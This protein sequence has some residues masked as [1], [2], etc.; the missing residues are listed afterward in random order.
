MEMPNYAS[1]SIDARGSEPRLKE[2]SARVAPGLEKSGGLYLRVDQLYSDLDEQSE[3][4][5]LELHSNGFEVVDRKSLLYAPPEPT[6]EEIETYERQLEIL[7]RF[8]VADAVPVG[9]GGFPN[10]VHRDDEADGVTDDDDYDGP[11]AH[12]EGLSTHCLPFRFVCRLSEEFPDLLFIVAGSTED[13]LDEEWEVKD[14]VPREISRAELFPREGMSKLYVRNG[15]VLDPP[16]TEIQEDLDVY[17]P[18]VLQSEE[19]I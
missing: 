5:W 8:G 15:E 16:M 2:L 4:V 9:L 19:P 1:F 14:G 11:V 18:D 7:R 10:W 12:M 6:P 3:H 13:Y 17:D